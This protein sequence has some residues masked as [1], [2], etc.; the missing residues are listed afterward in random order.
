MTQPDLSF[1]LKIEDYVNQYSEAIS[2]THRAHSTRQSN[3][4]RVKRVALHGE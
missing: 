2:C 1:R 4:L 3:C